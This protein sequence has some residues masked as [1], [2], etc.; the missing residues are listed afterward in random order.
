MFDIGLNNVKL[1]AG[2]YD[3]KLYGTSDVI[4]EILRNL[5]FEGTRLIRLKLT[6]MNLRPEG[7]I[8]QII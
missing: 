2:F 4:E 3:G 7:I 8:H 6:K 5:A 1:T